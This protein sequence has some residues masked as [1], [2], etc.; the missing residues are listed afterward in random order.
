LGLNPPQYPYHLSEWFIS[1]EGNVAE[2]QGRCAIKIKV[3]KII[4]G[5]IRNIYLS[6]LAIASCDYARIG[7]ADCDYARIG[8]A[9]CDF[10]GLALREMCGA[11]DK[12]NPIYHR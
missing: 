12:G 11:Y 7:D 9:D 3:I 2:L 1:T 4:L 5:S 6:C 10:S 8:D